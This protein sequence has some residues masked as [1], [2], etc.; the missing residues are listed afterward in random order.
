MRAP[1]LDLDWEEG[2]FRGLL[3]L[4]RRFAPDAKVPPAA[5][6]AYL[7]EHRDALAVLAQVLAGEPLRIREGRDAG[8][9]RGLDVLLPR[10]IALAPDAEANRALYVVRTAVSSAMRRITRDGVPPPEAGA[11][12]MASLRVAREA[13]DR[14][15]AELPLFAAAHEEAV[16]L[17]LS[18]RPDPGGLP[19]A[20]RVL[21]QARQDA[22]RGGCPWQDEAL[23]RALSGR[24]ERG[25]RSPEIPIW[26]EWLAAAEAGV[27]V[28]APDERPPGEEVTTELEAPAVDELRRVRIDPKEKEDAVLIHTFEKVETLDS[29][30]GGA[31]DTDGADELDAHLEALEEVKLGDL[32]RDDS[33]AHS[34]LRANLDLDLDVP[35]AADLEPS[36]PGI[37]YDEWDGRRRRYRRAW[38][39]VYPSRFPS[40]D[41]QW[42][43]ETLVQNRRLVRDLRRR[44]E[45]HRAGLRAVDRQLDGEDIDLAALVDAHA[46]RRAGRDGDA[47]LYVR[48][49]RRRRDFATTV[50]LDVSLSTDSWVENRRVLDVAR[51]AILVLGEVAH[52]LGDRLQV[53]A[54]ASHTRNRCHVWEVKGWRDP[55][56][57]GAARLGALDPRGYTRIGP[58][59]RH[60]TAELAREPADRRLLL[61]V[62]DGKPTD[63]DRYE[64]RYGIAD[65]RQALREAERSGVH[66]HALA[67]D[68][69]ARETLPALFGPGSWHILPHPG[70]LPEV[71]TTVYGRL[72]AR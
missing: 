29:H 64:G 27:E 70:R 26:G 14:L 59:L 46:A 30:R 24:A 31:R 44:L 38:C 21:E 40:R 54:F 23:V 5:G 13:A 16:R 63:Y 43:R 52:E 15:G 62:S 67:V 9:V 19:G 2:V 36:Q 6:A 66:P 33:P 65:V 35:D 25:P 53:L 55:W 39:T 8:G 56:S 10:E 50:L 48:K 45:I 42:A 1:H 58:A 20:E 32:V 7:E 37:A 18:G 41:A 22:L 60:A 51:E 47:R 28:G 3:A 4:W 71:L 11:A 57:E 12:A 68:A 17:A 34:L 72:T 69:V 49:E 61:L